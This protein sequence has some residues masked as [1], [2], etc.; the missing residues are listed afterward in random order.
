MSE[1]WIDGSRR[2]ESTVGEEMADKIREEML[3][4]S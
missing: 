2:L 3:F 1:T 4:E